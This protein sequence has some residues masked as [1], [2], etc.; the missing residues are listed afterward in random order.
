YIEFGSAMAVDALIQHALR[1]ALRARAAVAQAGAM[2]TDDAELGAF[3]RRA[4]E[5]LWDSP[6]SFLDCVQRAISNQY[7]AHPSTGEGKPTSQTGDAQ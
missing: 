2:L 3:V 6:K 1:D 4:V 7:A 5:R